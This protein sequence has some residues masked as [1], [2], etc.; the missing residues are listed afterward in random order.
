MPHYTTY[1]STLFSAQPA[2]ELTGT[3]NALN[4]TTNF[5][6]TK[7]E[8]VSIVHPTFKTGYDPGPVGSPVELKSLDVGPVNKTADKGWWT[9]DGADFRDSELD[10]LNKTTKFDDR[11]Y[12]PI[13]GEGVFKPQDIDTRGTVIVGDN[14]FKP[15][16]GGDSLTGEG[17]PTNSWRNA[18]PSPFEDRHVG[19]YDAN[20]AVFGMRENIGG[21]A[22]PG[23][24]TFMTESFEPAAGMDSFGESLNPVLEVGSTAGPGGSTFMTGQFDMP[25]DNV[26]GQAGPGG[27]T[28]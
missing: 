8:S 9:V 25:T 1:G 17:R 10:A 14:H 5:R 22:G 21:Q 15:G 19:D 4:E 23:G 27:T 6:P 13:S 16:R 24:T 26:G 18:D 12:S 20:D 11:G 3:F 2:D 7:G 28:F